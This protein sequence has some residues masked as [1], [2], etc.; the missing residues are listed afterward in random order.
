MVSHESVEQSPLSQ[1]A[2]E[3]VLLSVTMRR[4]DGS[5]HSYHDDVCLVRFQGELNSSPS[6][7]RNVD[8]SDL[9]FLEAESCGEIQIKVVSW[10]LYLENAA[11]DLRLVP[12]H[13]YQ[14]LPSIEKCNPVYCYWTMGF[15]C[16]GLKGGQSKKLIKTK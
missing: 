7:E 13:L 10:H 4:A 3:A 1:N 15:V 16:L 8:A 5:R 2:T 6:V 9:M 12:H 11:W 14:T